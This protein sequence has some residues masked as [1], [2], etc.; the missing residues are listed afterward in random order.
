M[1]SALVISRLESFEGR[2]PYLYLCTG[3]EVTVGIGHAIPTPA[4]ALQLTWSIDVRPATAVEIQGDY[5][6][7]AAAGKGL[8]ARSYAPLTRCRMADADID[9]LVSS[10]VQKFA[11]S[12]AAALPNWSTYPAAAQAALFDMAFNLGLGGLKKFP[13]LLAAVDAG[14]WEVAAAQ[15]HRQG[16]AETRN[17]QTADLFRQAAG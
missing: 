17:Q 15:C 3:G 10:D 8:T 14:Q 6:R 9:A 11:S 13:R 7:I 4:D 16:I 12:L 5:A 1:D 2:V